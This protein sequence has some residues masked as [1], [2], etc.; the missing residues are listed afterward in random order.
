MYVL[1][2]SVLATNVETI[3]TD[4]PT[5]RRG[6]KDAYSLSSFLLLLLSKSEKA[7]RTFETGEGVRKN[8]TDAGSQ[9]TF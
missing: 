6:Q 9:L 3:K 2:W 1:N 7:K 5:I 8:V 4:W